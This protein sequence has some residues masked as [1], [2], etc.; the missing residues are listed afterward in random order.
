[1]KEPEKDDSSKPMEFD[2]AGFTVT[3]LTAKQR[4]EYDVK[5][6]VM[7]K[8]VDQNGRAFESRLRPGFVVFEAIRSG[9]KISIGSV[10]DFEK[11][12]SSLDDG[13]SVLLRAKDAQGNASFIALRAPLK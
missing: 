11:F 4:K 8:D 5:G 1:M 3:G 10:S 12:A 6:G 13:E 7:I 2:K 9:K